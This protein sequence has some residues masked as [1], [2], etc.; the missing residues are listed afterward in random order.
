MPKFN[1][2]AAFVLA[3][4]ST[5]TLVAESHCP[6]NVESLPYRLLNRH[7]IVVPVNIDNSGPYNFLLDTG[8]QIT[9]IEPALAA[10]LHLATSGEASVRSAGASGSASLAPIDLL[11]AGSHSVTDLKVL[12]FDLGIQQAKSLDVR[13]ILGEDFLEKFD[14]LIDNE[15]SMV[16]LDDSG[17]MRPEVKG[18]HVELLSP[19]AE[20][21][22]GLPKPPV[23]LAKLSDGMRPVLLE[24]DSGADVSL[25]F[26]SSLLD[27]G[28]FRGVALQGNGASV[29]MRS[30][31]ILP[32]QDIKIG[33]VQVQK[34]P[35]I[36]FS[37]AQKSSHTSDFDGLLS[38]GLFRR[39]FI[40]HAEK[41][42]VLEP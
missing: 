20:T 29:Q 2:F 38:L 41:F 24:L 42:T 23:I 30:F 13:G 39:V 36:T 32:A 16:C 9:M 34:A 8:T 3:A 18:R 6:G 1:H 35:F 11:T 15:H 10:E 25:L 40:S 4:T 5:V 31:R 7:Q 19:V 12:V 21:P 17:R 28:A 22:G 27:L 14:L 37:E 33:S 26:S